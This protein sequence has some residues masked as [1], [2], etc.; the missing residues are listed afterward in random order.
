MHGA[1][2]DTAYQLGAW[3]FAWASCHCKQNSSLE[4][5][6]TI[7]SA[8]TMKAASGPTDTEKATSFGPCSSAPVRPFCNK[9]VLANEVVFPASALNTRTSWLTPA[10]SPTSEG[11]HAHT[12]SSHA[13]KGGATVQW[14]RGLHDHWVEG[15]ACWGGPWCWRLE[16]YQ[17]H[18]MSLR[19]GQHQS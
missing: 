3:P 19:H 17:P 9:Q 4:H 7:G 14:A 1:K 8:C 15:I 6:T 16:A 5:D 10:C 12:H 11:P 18:K 2:L 13:S